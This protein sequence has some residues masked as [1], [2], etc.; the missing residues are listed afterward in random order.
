MKNT[1]KYSSISHQPIQP[2]FLLEIIGG[3]GDELPDGVMLWNVCVSLNR[4]RSS[5][6]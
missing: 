3:F 6:C 1:L 4:I 2:G 5:F